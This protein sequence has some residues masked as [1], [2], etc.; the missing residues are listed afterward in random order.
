MTHDEEFEKWADASGFERAY[1]SLGYE[2]S[3]LLVTGVRAGHG[4]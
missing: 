4:G 3:D 2:M 1:L